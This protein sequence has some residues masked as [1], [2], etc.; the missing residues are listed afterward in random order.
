MRVTVG[1]EGVTLSRTPRI[2]AGMTVEES[3][4]Y[5]WPWVRK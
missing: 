3:V 4:T 1:R 2:V 5:H